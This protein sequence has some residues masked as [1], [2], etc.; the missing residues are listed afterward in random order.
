MIARRLS[1]LLLFALL[2][3]PGQSWAQ[4]VD[5]AI[6]TAP[7]GVTSTLG[8]PTPRGEISVVRERYFSTTPPAMTGSGVTLT[9]ADPNR[10]GVHSQSIFVRSGP[11]A[12]NSRD[13]ETS[14]ELIFPA[15]VTVIG[16]VSAEANLSATDISWGLSPT[17]NYTASS[18]GMEGGEMGATVLNANGTTS[19]FFRTNMNASPFTDE[20]RVLIDYGDAPPP[21]LS[22]VARVTTGDDVNIGGTDGGR[23]GQPTNYDAT[24]PLT[25]NCD[26]LIGTVCVT[27]GTPNPANSCEACIPGQSQVAYS[28][29]AAGTTCTAG[30]CNGTGS[31]VQC[32]AASDCDDGNA[33]TVNSCTNNACAT[34]S[35][36]A[37]D[38]GACG[39][40]EVCSG[41]PANTCT[42][43]CGDSQV[44]AP[45]TCDDGNTVSGDGCDSNCQNEAGF[46]CPTNGGACLTVAILSPTNGVIVQSDPPV[47]G[48]ATP[49]ATV[50][51]SWEDSAGSLLS[52]DVVATN[53]GTWTAPTQG[54]A[55][56][57]YDITASVSTSGGTLTDGPIR[58][59]VDSTAPAIALNTPTDNSTT[60]NTVVA[61]SGTVEVSSSVV[62]TITDES[63]QVVFS[64]PATNTNG[65]WTV[66]SSTLL[67][68]TYVVQATATDSAG[69][70]GS[71]S[72]TFTVD[73]LDP[74]VVI[75]S[76]ADDSTTADLR[77]ELSGTSEPGSTL[78]ITLVDDSGN[79]VF[80]ATVQA[81]ANGA[82]STVPDLDLVNGDYTLTAVAQ[83]AAGNT[84]DPAS[85]SFTVDT[86]V[87]P[88]DIL[89]PS[90]GDTL[91]ERLL[92]IDGA[93]EPN[94]EVTVVVRDDLGNE[95]ETLVVTSDENGIW[96]ATLSNGLADGDYTITASVEN[97]A[98]PPTTDSI[99]ISV[100]ATAPDLEMTSPQDG[101]EF[102]TGQPA[103]GG[104]GEPGID[105]VVEIFD[106][107]GNLVQTL[108]TTV[109]PMGTWT[110]TPSTPL[111][112]GSYSASATG[113][114]GAGNQTTDGPVSFEVSTVQTAPITTITQPA[115]G[116]LTNN[117]N[118]T[119]TGT[120]A[121]G[122]SVEVFVDG[123]SIGVT[124]ADQDGNWSIDLP[125]ALAEG[126][127]TIGA[128]STI[129]DSVGPLTEITLTVDLSAPSVVI[130]NPTGSVP[131]NGPVIVVSGTAEPGATVEIFVDGEKI[132][133]T[134]ADENGDWTF[135][136]TLPTGEHTIEAT[137]TDEAGN[138]GS[139]GIVTLNV[140]DDGDTTPDDQGLFYLAGNG[141]A[142][143]P[144]SSHWLLLALGFLMVGMR[145]RRRSKA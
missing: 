81:D 67:D 4:F 55:D 73:T 53:N 105:V 133:E 10:D 126:E 71:D 95:I 129:D 66:D 60:N 141:C 102:S 84:S 14:G 19:V 64:G 36:P 120:S 114:D 75:I 59:T 91:T 8:G 25:P 5:S 78:D 79:T 112:E 3:I 123:V 96:T 121:P 41:A 117:A 13:P 56:G 130:T 62:V 92:E 54:L 107:G 118:P 35:V 132:G 93:T 77:P 98:G 128:Q 50:T 144:A 142:T 30:V 11:V 88:L 37:G 33:C 76:P 82:W 125:E 49:G 7:A 63:N 108:T 17:I 42:P 140:I 1:T 83:D 57:E 28:P 38:A 52:V 97:V 113:T 68:G 27:A 26:C 124:T 116:A 127:H 23:T 34:T 115:D 16:V 80:S 43:L 20:F 70:S 94:T 58:I 24:I 51:L 32:V 46:T 31:C 12:D 29:T 44:L 39:A 15:G 100:D 122:A 138:T 45:E 47:S 22:F 101:E 65:N 143:T 69:N 87:K 90:S 136:V 6:Y 139:S 2:C 85:H 40:G 18:R 21:N 74:V 89:N 135:E 111:A 131:V 134:T 104:T 109:S 48:T 61:V 9:P 106:S 72:A 99:G 110:V 137:S 86:S 119:I 103:F 145:K